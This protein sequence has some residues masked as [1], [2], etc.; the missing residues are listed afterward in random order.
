M[1]SKNKISAILHPQRFV[2][3]RVDGTLRIVRDGYS[4]ARQDW[5][6]ISKK[7]LERDGYQCRATLIDDSGSRRRCPNS[8]HTGHRLEVHH[9]KELSKG[10]KTIMANLLTLCERCHRQRHHHLKRNH[11]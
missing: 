5:W 8:R 3:R 6:T 1:K 4:N 7:V 10:G 11:K 2:K 9:I